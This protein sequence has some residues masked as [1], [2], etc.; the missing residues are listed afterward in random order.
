MNQK[1]EN[2]QRND[3]YIYEFPGILDTI[4]DPGFNGC[5]PF[6]PWHNRTS[7]SQSAR[8]TGEP[9]SAPLFQAHLEFGSSV[10][11]MFFR[12]PETLC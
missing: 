6:L 9:Q 7:V 11:N 12:Y 4:I 5:Q 3:L 1:Q 2:K 10:I 8:Q